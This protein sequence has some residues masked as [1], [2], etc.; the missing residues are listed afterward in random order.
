MCVHVSMEEGAEDKCREF[1][2][3]AL[4]YHHD[5]PEAL[6]LMANYLFSSEKIQVSLYT[7]AFTHIHIHTLRMS[8]HHI[9]ARICWVNYSE[10]IE[11]HVI[12]QQMDTYINMHTHRRVMLIRM[13]ITGQ[14][15]EVI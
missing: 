13:L 6:Q 14:I 3:R 10:Q 15:I 2:E 5:N 7:Y 4:H 12:N 1:I 9:K 8:Y 11:L